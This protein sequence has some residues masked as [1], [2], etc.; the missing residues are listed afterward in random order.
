[1]KK[2]LI[3]FAALA[4]LA[5]CNKD[6][7]GN[8]VK[9]PEVLAKKIVKIEEVGE[10][11]TTFTYNS[12][13]TIATID[14]RQVTYGK[15]TVKYD[16]TTYTLEEGK[17]IKSKDEY[18]DDAYDYS[19]D[20]DGY[21]TQI[22]WTEDKEEERYAFTFKKG[23]LTKFVWSGKYE[24]NGKPEEDF[25]TYDI[26]C[27]KQANNLNIDL[28]DY[29]LNV[30]PDYSVLLGI[31]GNRSVNLPEKVVNTYTYT[32]EDT[33]KEVKAEDTYTFEYKTDAE[34]YITEIT[35]TN[36]DKENG[37]EVDRDK[38][39]YRITYEK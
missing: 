21:L 38:I 11:S 13:G 8:D 18:D 22:A 28:T 30:Y 10:G 20:K 31:A 19:Y 32:D 7:D 4:L 33:D 6:D 5:A 39:T 24:E 34:G 9:Q 3:S 15:N 26:T 29:L 16:G 1:M 37:Q 35:C 25:D 14:G 17:T 27:G 12:D 36:V 23:N 2:L